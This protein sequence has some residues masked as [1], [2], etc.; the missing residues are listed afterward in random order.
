[1]Y[2]VLLMLYADLVQNDVNLECNTTI[3]YSQWH[4]PGESIA[5]HQGEQQYFP[6]PV[7]LQSPAHQLPLT[8]D[9]KSSAVQ[10]VK[11]DYAARKSKFLERIEEELYLEDI[12]QELTPGN[13]KKKFH[14][15]LCWEEKT[16]IEILENRSVYIAVPHVIFSVLLSVTHCLQE[17]DCPTTMQLHL[18]CSY[19]LHL[20]FRIHGPVLYWYGTLTKA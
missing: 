4:N 8:V 16:H 5:H 2:V 6:P 17:F 13:Y 3:T 10:R 7:Q 15:L 18:H 1:M 20:C 14:N 11:Q 9:T 19:R 12:Q